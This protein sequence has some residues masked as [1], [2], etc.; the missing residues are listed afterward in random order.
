M[1]LDKLKQFRTD[2]YTIL[3]KAFV[4]QTAYINNP[5]YNILNFAVE[6]KT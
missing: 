3:G 4:K 1:T 2:V 6:L 5:Q